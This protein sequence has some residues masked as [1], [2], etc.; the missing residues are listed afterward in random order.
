[1]DA[2]TSAC[3]ILSSVSITVLSRKIVA[4]SGFVPVAVLDGGGLIR[5]YA[6]RAKAAKMVNDILYKIQ[7][8]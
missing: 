2:D 6:K 7:G 4:K 3:G 1:M 5:T 8:E